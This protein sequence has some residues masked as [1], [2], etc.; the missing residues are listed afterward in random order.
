MLSWQRKV[1]ISAGMATLDL[2]N[3]GIALKWDT[4]D[5]WKQ[6]FEF[7]RSL[8]SFRSHIDWVSAFLS[9]IGCTILYVMLHSAHS[10]APSC[11]KHHL[12]I[13]HRSKWRATG[14]PASIHKDRVH[15]TWNGDAVRWDAIRVV[16]AVPPSQLAA[17]PLLGAMWGLL[18]ILG[19]WPW[20]CCGVFRR[21]SK[22]APRLPGTSAG[23]PGVCR[24]WCCQRWLLCH[25]QEAVVL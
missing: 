12:C 7:S 24:V 25:M 23:S 18:R 17:Q 1:G 20:A 15:N 4:E 8:S 3:I 11:H 6:Q 9:F 19:S 10:H 22:T 14:G 16:C 5:D 2:A 13:F 21:V